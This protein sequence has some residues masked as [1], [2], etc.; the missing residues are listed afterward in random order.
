MRIRTVGLSSIGSVGLSLSWNPVLNACIP[1]SGQGHYRVQLRR[2]SRFEN[3]SNG[4][5]LCQI[6]RLE[7]YSPMIPYTV[8]VAGLAGLHVIFSATAG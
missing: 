2:A 5:R 7:R 3:E 1:T 8:A 6:P 4:L